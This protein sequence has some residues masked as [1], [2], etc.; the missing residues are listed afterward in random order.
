MPIPPPPAGRCSRDREV[1]IDVDLSNAVAV[2]TGAGSG[3]GRAA[4]HSLAQRGARVVVTD[5]DGDRASTVAGE[6]GE[7]A[8]ALRV[9]VTKT[10]DLEVARDLALERFGRVDVIMNNVGI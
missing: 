1:L 6:L 2:I 5:I 7:R 9:D 10:G 4:A 3:I 8:A